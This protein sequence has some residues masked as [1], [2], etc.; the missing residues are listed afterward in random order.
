[1]KF[2]Q[3]TSIANIESS[4]TILHSHT[5]QP[6]LSPFSYRELVLDTIKTQPLA[7]DLQEE[8]SVKGEEYK[9]S[10]AKNQMLSKDLFFAFSKERNLDLLIA[11]AKNPSAP[12][13]VLAR[14]AVSMAEDVRVSVAENLSTPLNIL[15]QLAADE[16]W[17]VKH[18]VAS[19]PNFALN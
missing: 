11:L 15:R 17:D 5:H 8:I 16:S 18:S 13:E 6:E 10:L 3:E 7:C 9:L 2:D 4:L 19:N 12:M 1:M 14:L